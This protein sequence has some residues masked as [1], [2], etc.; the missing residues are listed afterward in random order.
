MPIKEI[1]NEKFK[2]KEIQLFT[3]TEKFYGN[4][5]L[6]RTVYDIGEVKYIYCEVSFYNKWF[7]EDKNWDADLS[8]LITAADGR[9]VAEF[10][11]SVA[12]SSDQNIVISAEG[13]GNDQGTF[14]KEGKF[15][16]QVKLND[17][18]IGEQD[19]YI[20]SNGAVS[21]TGFPYF[22]VS[23]I[24]PFEGGYDGL[25]K[26]SRKYLRQFDVKNTRY[27]YFECELINLLKTNKLIPL[28]IS[29]T[30]YNDSG[31]VKAY[32]DYF[33]EFASGTKSFDFYLGYGNANG[34]YWKEDNYTAELMFMGK[35]FAVLPFVVANSE[36]VLDAP[37]HQE[38]KLERQEP[39]NTQVEEETVEEDDQELDDLIGLTQVKREV[40]ELADYLKFLK[41]RE[42]KG[43]EEKQKPKL[44]LLFEGNPG[45]GKTTVA[46]MLG[47]IYKEMGL[48]SNGLVHEVSRVD[49]VAEFIGQTAPKTKAAI[50]KA[51]GGILFIDEAY[52][53][54]DR[55]DSKN[56]YGREV[57]EVII[58]EMSDGA[59]DIAFIFAG[60]PAEMNA[61]INSNPGIQSRI[62]TSIHFE[63]YTPDE[64]IEIARYSAERKG[65]EFDTKA[66]E[67]VYE[68][69]VEAY[70]NRD[71]RFGNAR[72][73]NGIVEEGKQ[74]LALRLIREKKIEK[75]D[76]K[77]LSTI[78]YEDIEPFITHNRKTK[79]LLPINEKLLD[80]SLEKLNRLIGLKTVKKEVDEMANLVKYYRETNKYDPQSFTLHT[81][82]T[83]NPGTGK[84]TVARLMADIYKALG[85][86]ERGHLVEVDRKALVAEF[87]GQT[88]A[89]TSR[90]ID[91]AKGG[92]LFID[93]A[94]A[95]NSGSGSNDYGKEA[96]ETLL[97]RMEDER[98]N[99]IVIAAGYPDEMKQFLEMNPGLMSRFDKTIHFEDYDLEELM[100]IADMLFEEKDLKLDEEA[101]KYL[102]NYLSLLLSKKNKYF[103]NA[104]AV[105]KIVEEVTRN[106]HLRMAKMSKDERAKIDTSIVNMEDLEEFNT[107][108]LPKEGGAKIGFRKD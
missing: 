25:T 96:I 58:K 26:A 47:K 35:R 19:F 43:F 51:R 107:E 41:I 15:T 98:G 59:G 75:A 64:L 73:V 34:G 55:G 79:V 86:L 94:Y 52:A 83:G 6:Y 46:K 44:S 28:E 67:A 99:F 17:Q 33:H 104:R 23:S 97:K 32:C 12:V 31:Q 69:L 42:S 81:V 101:R 68:Y 91:E 56:D 48:L 8:F 78:V 20:L 71:R 93:E 103:G 89:K 36:I 7:D 3:S 84:T 85:V 108:N 24:K 95:L 14:W 72:L 11:K 45:T 49:L 50:D 22:K 21:E 9:K 4:R 105:R 87:V 90:M 5:R 54:T 82:F 62:S 1:S 38:G 76:K 29:L 30:V 61:F 65:V 102:E 2:V 77:E 27:I 39:S 16:Y 18:E 13:W 92:V 100:Q 40:N 88:A 60:Y 70:R 37:I 66:A 80:E 53:L 106:Q 63:D 10:K 57:V 74:N